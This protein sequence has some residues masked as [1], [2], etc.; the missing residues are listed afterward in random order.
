[1][2]GELGS[3]W[4]DEMVWL[5]IRTDLNAL[6]V[7]GVDDIRDDCTSTEGNTVSNVTNFGLVQASE[8]Y[9]NVFLLDIERRRPAMSASLSKKVEIILNAVFHLCQFSTAQ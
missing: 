7:R 2:W 9:D 6:V 3:D 1:M 5:V 4:E 8:I